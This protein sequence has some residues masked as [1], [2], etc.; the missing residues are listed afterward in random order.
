[1][2]MQDHDVADEGILFQPV[3]GPPR[4][5]APEQVEHFNCHRYIADLPLLALAAAVAH[6]AWFDNL[7]GQFRA[8]GKEAHSINGYQA[9]LKSLYDLATHALLL[10]YVEDLIGPDIVC[11]GTHYFCKEPGDARAVPFHQDAIYWPFRPL[12]TVTAW[13]AID[14]V[15]L[16]NGPMCFLPGSHLEGPYETRARE[17]DVVLNLETVGFEQLG[18]PC[19]LTMQAGRVSLHTDLLVHGSALNA[20]LNRR[21][22]LRLRFVPPDVWVR[23]PGFEGWTR[24]ALLCRGSCEDSNWRPREVPATDEVKF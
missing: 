1:M 11:W 13:I 14:D 22:G 12:R 18:E 7:R 10:D 19:P 6:R 20:S 8:A 4:R 17:G 21:C 15:T 2:P 16:D 3:A 9:R 23:D 5:L 24:T